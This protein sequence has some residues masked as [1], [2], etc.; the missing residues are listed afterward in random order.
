MTTH[1][2]KRRGVPAIFLILL[3]I[4][5]GAT[6]LSLDDSQSDSPAPAESAGEATAQ[7][8]GQVAPIS[9]VQP[10]QRAAFSLLRGATEELP[11]TVKAM[12]ASEG[13]GLN[14]GLAQKATP[15]GSPNPI[16]VIP[17]DD[18]IC[19]FVELEG[20]GAASCDTTDGAVGNG[21]D[22]AIAAP[23]GEGEAAGIQSTVGIVP[24]DVGA[25]RF[26]GNAH[27]PEKVSLDGNAYYASGGSQA[28][29]ELVR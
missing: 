23:A 11:G 6:F 19:V 28:Q 26:R 14:F 27:G 20:S 24:D 2:L 9:A 25:V 10:E 18:W 1:A 7:P 3:G 15:A 5:V 29:P 22:L 4:A 17:G 13:H 12:L 16:W 8:A 21:I